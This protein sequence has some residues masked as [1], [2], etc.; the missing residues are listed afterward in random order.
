[1]V[2]VK[3]FFKI[4]NSG[5]RIMT[6]GLLVGLFVGCA[7]VKGDWEKAQRL[8]TVEAYQRF[9]NKHPQSEFS[10][11]AKR[12]I[13]EEDWAKAQ[14]LNAEKAYQQ[15]L[16]KHPQSEFSSKAK[17]Y[18]KDTAL[19]NV[20]LKMAPPTKIILDS[21]YRN[22]PTG[23]SP[24]NSQKLLIP[25]LEKLLKEGADPNSRRIDGYRSV[26]RFSQKSGKIESTFAFAGSPGTIVEHNGGSKS[27][28]SFCREFELFRAAEIIEQ[29]GAK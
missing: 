3:S 13:M 23:W 2:I 7:T 14:S 25:E 18:L 9:L 10:N 29:Y 1:M 24:E 22:V 20:V 12:H 27:L 19:A 16:D 15:F 26:Y 28:L 5:L 21:N 8:N 11:G 6:V 4:N 17:H